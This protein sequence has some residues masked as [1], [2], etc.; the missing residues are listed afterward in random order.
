MPGELI[1]IKTYDKVRIKAYEKDY[2][3]VLASY[4]NTSVKIGISNQRIIFYE[5]S[6]GNIWE[7]KDKIPFCYSVTFYHL[8]RQMKRQLGRTMEAK[9]G[10]AF[11]YQSNYTLRF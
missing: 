11:K 5:D 10:G 2:H 1:R 8:L 7:K 3:T 9:S 6:Y 4:R